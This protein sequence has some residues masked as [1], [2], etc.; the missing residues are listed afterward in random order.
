MNTDNIDILYMRRALELAALGEGRVA[1]NPMVGAVIVARQRII[2][3]GFHAHYGGPHAEVNAI[4]SVKEED[5][6]LLGEA[7]IYVTLEPCSHYGKTPPCALLI[8]KTG[9]PRVVTGAPDPNPLVNGK[10][11][12][13]LKEAGA[14][15]SEGVLRDECININ[16]RF[17]TSQLLQRPW[18]QLKWAC[19]AN[20]CIAALKPGDPLP[21]PVK[22]S[23]P[24]SR[25]WMHRQRA[26]ADLIFV[27]T[28]TLITDNPRLDC[29]LWPGKNPVP[30]SFESVRI[31]SDSNFMKSEH[32]LMPHSETPIEFLKRI[33]AEHKIQSVMVEGGAATLQSFLNDSL[34]DEIRIELSPIVI[35]HGL[36]APAIDIP[37]IISQGFTLRQERCR[38]NHQILTLTKNV[39]SYFDKSPDTTL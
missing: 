25:V 14:E 32:I 39:A 19:S 9:I 5:R 6:H 8:A 26:S 20:G 23:N 1:P 28:N 15:V 13:I 3:E 33:Y 37:K 27:G 31:P 10:G 17:M 21:S 2:G 22:I 4:K 35:P 16:K 7:T 11:I 18:V 30:A 34:Y 36:P 12:K 38:G 29:R 24:V